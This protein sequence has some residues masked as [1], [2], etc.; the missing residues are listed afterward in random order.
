M[1]EKRVNLGLNLYMGSGFEFNK[2]GL[3]QW[4]DSHNET[5]KQEEDARLK[6]A[7]KPVISP[8]RK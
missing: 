3:E 8:S 2:K 1:S 5:V 7:Q 4:W 6:R